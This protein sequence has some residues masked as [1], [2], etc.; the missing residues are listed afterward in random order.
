MTPNCTR[1]GETTARGCEDW[2][3]HEGWTPQ[4]KSL[5][6]YDTWREQTAAVED[7]DAA[8]TRTH[9]RALGANR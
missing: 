2:D 6:P 5:A 7:M 4:P 8:L 9:W 1:C 3:C